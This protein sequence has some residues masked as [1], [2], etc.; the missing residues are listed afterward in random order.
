MNPH[1]CLAHRI[2]NACREPTPAA[3]SASSRH[4]SPTRNAPEGSRGS[5]P[6]TTSTTPKCT[7][8]R[9]LWD[10]RSCSRRARSRPA[11]VGAV[12]RQ[13]APAPRRTR[14]SPSLGRRRR[15]PN[16]PAARRPAP[17][18]GRAR[19]SPSGKHQA[20]PFFE[21]YCARD[22]KGR[23]VSALSD[24]PAHG[25]HERSTEWRTRRPPDPVSPNESRMARLTARGV[26]RTS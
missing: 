11:G 22:Q 4:F 19:G 7:G 17:L 5:D 18:S 16:G 9:I 12:P 14:C 3:I 13:P 1:G 23:T 2:L 25:S 24:T 21:P 10:E 26:R 15:A 8:S 20:K 6:S